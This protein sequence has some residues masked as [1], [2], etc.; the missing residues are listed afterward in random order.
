MRIIIIYSSSSHIQH[1]TFELGV[2]QVSIPYLFSRGNQI[3]YF[4]F[5]LN[6]GSFVWQFAILLVLNN[7]ANKGCPFWPLESSASTFPWSLCSFDNCAINFFTKVSISPWWWQFSVKDSKLSNKILFFWF[8]Q[9]IRVSIFVWCLDNW[10]LKTGVT[11]LTTHCLLFIGLIPSEFL[12]IQ[13]WSI[14]VFQQSIPLCINY[15]MFGST[16]IKGKNGYIMSLSLLRWE[17]EWTVWIYDLMR[18]G[19]TRRYAN[20]IH[21]SSTRLLIFHCVWDIE[22]SLFG[23]LLAENFGWLRR[24]LYLIML[25]IARPM[26]IWYVGT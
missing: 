5:Q 20:C 21:K 23:P 6:S 8:P 12:L 13:I 2:L 19:G 18:M 25:L 22:E 15:L 14:L 24:G 17:Q 1:E 7:H 26:T 4:Q 11:V 16:T 3:C 10:C 9:V